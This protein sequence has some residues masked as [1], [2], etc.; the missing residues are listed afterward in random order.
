MRAREGFKEKGEPVWSILD[1]VSDD[2]GTGQSI[3]DH[4]ASL[5]AQSQLAEAVSKL[6]TSLKTTSKATIMFANLPVE[7]LLRGELLLDEKEED[8]NDHNDQQSDLAR[9]LPSPA[10]FP[11]SASQHRSNDSRS[12]SPSNRHTYRPAPL[13]SRVG[14]RPTVRFFPWQTL[15]PLENPD[16]LKR[17]VVGTDNL[18]WRF[19]DIWSPTL[20]SVPIP[21]DELT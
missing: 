11:R 10:Y 7:V 3:E 12:P 20:S 16:E 21:R 14:R 5:L 17:N 9:G 18:L 19:L 4:L 13:F 2:C 15:L 8:S 6:Y 1:F